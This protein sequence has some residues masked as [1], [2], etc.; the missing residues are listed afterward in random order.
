MKS[1]ILAALMATAPLTAPAHADDASLAAKVA[2]LGRINSA[3]SATLSPDKRMLAYL[4]N[5]SGSPQI[6]VRDLVDSKSDRQL[7][8]LPDPVGDMFWSPRGDWIAYTVAPGG[9]LNTQIWLVKP[10]GGGARRL[11]SGGKENNALFGWTR[12]GSRL[13]VNSNKDHP[14]AQDAGLI[15]VATGRWTAITSNKGN[16]YPA[17]VRGERAIVRRLIGRG[18]V[19]AYAV[20]LGSGAETL[21]TPHDGKAETDWGQLSADGRTVYLA[22]NVGRDRAAFG[23]TTIGADGSAGPIRY[24]AARDDA[25]AESAL[26]SSDG[27]VAALTWNV[28]GR[29][30]LAWFDP[31]RSCRSTSHSR[32]SSAAT[33]AVWSWSVWPPTERP[34]SIW[35]TSRRER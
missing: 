21:L 28:N 23:S 34:T 1:I 22:S 6:W 13:M 3:S 12:D 4:S 20:D 17:D 14:A 27:K 19:N 16:N 29:S 5:A 32:L 10:D 18:D 25:V 26:L 11:T 9:G 15:D 35:W 2:A 30:E 8:N 31:A 24:F 7:T 33:A